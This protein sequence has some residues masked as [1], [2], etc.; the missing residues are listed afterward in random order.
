MVYYWN[1]TWVYP[2]KLYHEL[3]YENQFD[4]SQKIIYFVIR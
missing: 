2:L 1:I 3:F 4:G